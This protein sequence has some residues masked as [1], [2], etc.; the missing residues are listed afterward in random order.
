MV[1]AIS[2]TP[3]AKT[4]QEEGSRNQPSRPPLLPSEKDNGGFLSKRPKGREVTSRY[5]ST[6]S[7]SSSSRRCPSPLVSRTTPSTDPSVKR[8]QSA[9]RR[10]SSTGAGPTDAAKMLWT[11]TRSLSVSFQGESFSLPIS[12]QK[13][14]PNSSAAAAATPDRSRRTTPLRGKPDGPRQLENSKPLEHHRWPARS[15]QSNPLTRS[16]DCTV[17]KFSRVAATPNAAVRASFD[18]SDCASSQDLAT[19]DTD[20]VSSGS[21]SGVSETAGVGGGRSTPRRMAVPAR[22]WQETNSRLRRLHDPSTPKVGTTKKTYSDSPVSSPRTNRGLSSPIRGP[23]RPASPSKLS[24]SSPRGMPSPSRVRPSASCFSNDQLCNGTPSILSFALDVRRGKMGENR[25]EEAHLLRLLHNRHLQWRFTNAR[26]NA[27][28]SVQKLTAKRNL[29]N[30]WIATSELRNSVTV[31]RVQLQSWRQTLKLITILK[32]Q[33]PYLEEWALVERE[34]SNCLLGAI[35]DLKASTLRLPVAE[36]AKADIQKVK[37]AVGSAVDVMQAMGS[38]ICFLLSKVEGM[39]SLVTDLARVAAQERALLARCKD[40]LSSLAA[41]Q[42]EE[43]S[44][45]GHLLQLK[46]VAS[47]TQ[48]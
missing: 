22:F 5:L 45:R 42:V 29:Y 23:A 26:V 14:A 16:L 8:S 27:A 19:S 7:T 17:E 25:I 39:N 43:A 3:A 24:T 37:V 20:S 36:G 48:L 21:N 31:K 12:K 11:S 32:G 2:A 38:S 13:P 9:E 40:L 46:H 10:R 34:H 1:A 28:L 15:R 44:L 6:P 18:G 33:L 41:M 30:A 47:L 4:Q 35:E